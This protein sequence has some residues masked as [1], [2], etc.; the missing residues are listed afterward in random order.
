MSLWL[1]HDVEHAGQKT[2]K[3]QLSQTV[4]DVQYHQTHGGWNP[5]LHQKFL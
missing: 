2:L 1:M 5:Q 4:A 3:V